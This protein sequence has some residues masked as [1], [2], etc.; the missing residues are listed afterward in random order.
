VIIFDIFFRIMCTNLE[1]ADLLSWVASKTFRRQYFNASFG[2]MLQEIL[3]SLRVYIDT[4]T[5]SSRSWFLQFTNYV[6]MMM[7]INLLDSKG[8][9]SATLN[10]TKLVPGS[11]V[12]GLLYLVQRGGAWAGCG[13]AQSPHRCTK[14]N[15]PPINGHCTNHCIAVWWSVALRF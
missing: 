1:V 2:G 5:V 10:N 13:P 11:L 4:R 8:N 7:T 9:Y 12:G 3:S 14:C 15:S 6:V